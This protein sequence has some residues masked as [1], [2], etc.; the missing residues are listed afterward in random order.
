MKTTDHAHL[1][2]SRLRQLMT[3]ENIT[4]YLVPLRDEYGFEYVPDHNNRLKWLTGFTGSNG[5]AVIGR[6]KAAVFTDGR[7]T[8]QISAEV[9]ADLYETYDLAQMHW[10]KWITENVQSKDVIAYD[11]KLITAHDFKKIAEKLKSVGAVLKS[12]ENL[13]DQV[14]TD[15]KPADDFYCEPYPLKYAGEDVVSKRDR[16]DTK[17]KESKA[18]ALFITESDTVNWL[19]NVRGNDVAHTPLLLSFALVKA[20]GEIFLYVAA[21]KMTPL[22]ALMPD[23]VEIIALDKMSFD[24]KGQKIIADERFL[25]QFVKDQI[26]NCGAKL[27]NQ[28]DPAEMLKCQKNEAELEGAK[29]AHLIDAIAICSLMQWLEESAPDLVDELDVTAKLKEIRLSHPDCVDLSFTT[30]AG[31]GPNGA[32]VHYSSKPETTRRLKDDPLLLL[33]SGGQYKMGTTDIT[34][35]FS[36]NPRLVTDEIKKHYTLVLKGHIALSSA[37]FPEGTL[38]VQL[39][40][41]ARQYL[42]EHGLDYAHGTG[43]GVGSYLSV[44]EGHMGISKRSMGGALKAGMILSNEPGYYQEGAYGIRLENLVYIKRDKKRSGKDQTY[45]R[46]ENLTYVPFEFELIDIDLLSKA[47]RIW[48]KAYH[49]DIVEKLSPN[50][51]SLMAY[52]ESK[53]QPFCDL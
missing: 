38:G 51:K 11:P 35:V 1:H 21:A 45:Y 7:Y 50:D 16:L 52:I 19:L 29:K 37:V 33:D 40:V 14:W 42:W 8:L 47:E 49:R 10:I 41:L 31:S 12:S 6:E 39:D 3:E 18:D 27:I 9:N 13:I 4:Y 46:F 22:K 15:R 17:I 32:I 36:L 24:F 44:H 28:P 2:L 25:S 5:F 26:V 43:H 34:R 23:F 20:T 30:I 48:L 53:C